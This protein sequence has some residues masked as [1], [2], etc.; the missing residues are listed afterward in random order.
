MSDGVIL[1]NRRMAIPQQQ[2]DRSM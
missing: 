1:N 2:F